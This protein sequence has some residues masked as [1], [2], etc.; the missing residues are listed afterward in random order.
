MSIE[1]LAAQQRR[2]TVERAKRH[3]KRQDDVV[4]LSTSLSAAVRGNTFE[5]SSGSNGPFIPG[6]A[7]AFLGPGVVDVPSRGR[8]SQSFP[9]GSSVG[10]TK[11]FAVVETG[12][13]LEYWLGGDRKT[14]IK[15]LSIL[16]AQEGQ[17]AAYG[18]ATGP[19]LNDWLLTI[20]TLILPAATPPVYKIRTLKGDGSLIE[21][22]SPKYLY[23]SHYGAGF[24]AS[25]VLENLTFNYTTTSTGSGS[26][27]ALGFAIAG[28]INGSIFGGG[29]SWSYDY[30]TFDGGATHYDRFSTSTGVLNPDTS[31]SIFDFKKTGRTN[32]SSS[33]VSDWAQVPQISGGLQFLSGA[34]CTEGGQVTVQYGRLE[35]HFVDTFD[36]NESNSSYSIAFF[37]ALEEEEGTR[38]RSEVR[39]ITT[40]RVDCVGDDKIYPVTCIVD[41]AAPTLPDRRYYVNP[42]QSLGRPT[43]TIIRVNTEVI[44]ETKNQTVFIAP[45]VKKGFSYSY[46]RN[47]DLIA[48]QDI[49]AETRN[50]YSPIIVYNS[51]QNYIYSNSIGGQISLY[52]KTQAGEELVQAVTFGRDSTIVPHGTKTTIYSPN[53]LPNTNDWQTK[54][55]SI[56]IKQL[57]RTAM[58][59]EEQADLLKAKISPLPLSVLGVS[60]ANAR[61]LCVKYWPKN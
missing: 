40:D 55:L 45:G 57:T 44:T 21:S 20:K 14:P 7:A 25:S 3:A 15:I 9:V 30:T 41:P 50:S 4:F 36:N 34:P 22:S 35:Q 48:S 49:A 29:L 54:A 32:S 42:P 38:T 60:A 28:V 16:K 13:A 19:G 6:Q 11:L 51:G 43:S 27:A 37:T 17:A 61:V 2:E 56:D 18:E 47:I 53:N 31:S 12:T 1:D 59:F 24:W 10:D 26:G 46:Q 58:I 52:E 39:N 23:L 33:Q 5:A 8:D